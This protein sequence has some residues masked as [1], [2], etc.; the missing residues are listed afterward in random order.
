MKIANWVGI[1]GNQMSLYT[2]SPGQQDQRTAVL[3]MH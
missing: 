1:E 2:M 3:G